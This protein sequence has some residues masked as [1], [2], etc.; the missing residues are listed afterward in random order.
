M[1]KQTYSIEG[2]DC[3][4]E[5]AM[6]RRALA[7]LVSHDDQL[8]F[9]VIHGRMT[10]ERPGA[11]CTIEAVTAAVR[12]TG[13]RATLH[14]SESPA[15]GVPASGWTRHLRLL[16]SGLSGFCM[17]IGFAIHALQQGWL[18]A[19]AEDPLTETSYPLATTL[20]YG[21]ATVSGA[22]FVAP[23]AWYAL[24]T[25]RPDINLLMLVAVAGAWAIGSQFEAGV[26]SF[27][28]AA[29]LLLETW[30]VG[31]ARRAIAA[32]MALRPAIA[33][34]LHGD[35]LGHT[36]ATPVEQ[37]AP[38]A[39]VV[40]RPGERIPLDGAVVSGRTSV[41]EAPIT[42]EARPVEKDAGDRVF[43]GTINN[44]GV[45][46]FCVDRAAQDTQLARIIQLVEEAQANRA[47]A[48][49][50]VDQF[51]RRYTPVMMG[52]AL[53]VAAGSPLVLG[54]PWP[55]AIYQALVLL[56]IACPC[57]LVISTPVSIV[58]GLASAARAGVLIKGGAYLEA[59]ARIRAVALDKTGT[60]TLGRPEVQQI[61]PINGNTAEELLR[62]AAA[63]EVLSRHPIAQAIVRAAKRAG[64]PIVAA[65]AYRALEGK[66]AEATVD[67]VRYWIGNHRLLLEAGHDQAGLARQASRLEDAGHSVVILGDDTTVRGL[68]GVADALRPEAACVVRA[69][70]AAGIRHVALLTGDNAGTARAVA[71]AT[72]VDSYQAELLPEDKLDA[73][74]ALTAQFG[75]VA[76]VGDGVNDAPA[77]AKAALGIAMGAAGSDAA[78][79]TADIALMGDRLERLPWLVRHSRRVL[80]VIQQN[81]AVALGLKLLVLIAAMLG[82]GTL[83]SAV[84][85]DMGASLLVIF[86]G[87]RLLGHTRE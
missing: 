10:I 47:P 55:A 63:M 38:G 64:L 77:M 57:A 15:A 13:M 17:L 28:F 76:M 46:V 19:L 39:R 42:G 25:L 66:G 30:S 69:L 83:W 29:A 79:E 11:T 74:R 80:R 26:V 6:L 49:Q 44:E 62:I 4:N 8:Q 20:L 45:F 48:E 78:L 27:L 31:R 3:P 72:G 82:Y 14:D 5:V 56:L 18:A 51:A 2:L 9:D 34:V 52:L 53:L 65:S 81:I 33:Q 61:L 85:A 36:H 84:V 60:L 54:T 67:G 1:Q 40:V 58:A 32:L 73:I 7:D 87:L 35:D 12:L 50:W 71:E 68:I 23:R 41:N 16:V 75:P 70:R 86:N 43:A 59:P 24:R 21:A 22:W 37:V